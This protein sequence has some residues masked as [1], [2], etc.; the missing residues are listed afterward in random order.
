MF[1]PSWKFYYAY[2]TVATIHF[3]KQLQEFWSEVHDRSSKVDNSKN[4]L[5]NETEHKQEQGNQPQN[6]GKQLEKQE[7]S[8]TT[9]NNN[10]QQ[11]A[12]QPQKHAWK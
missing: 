8:T 4:N 6:H 7:S 5:P 12:Q 10:Q 11:W 9:T 3:S 1:K 2:I